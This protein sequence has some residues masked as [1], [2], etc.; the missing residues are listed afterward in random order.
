LIDPEDSSS[1]LTTDRTLLDIPSD[2]ELFSIAENLLKSNVSIEKVKEII[3]SV[4]P[5]F[6]FPDILTDVAMSANRR[7]KGFAQDVRDWI[8]LTKGYWHINDICKEMRVDGKVRLN[9]LYTVLN[10]LIKEGTIEHRGTRRGE[11][12][13]VEKKA[14]IMN[15]R[16]VDVQ[17]FKLWLPFDLMDEAIIYPKNIIVFAGEKSSGK[18][19]AMLNI[20]KHN[21]REHEIVYLCAEGGVVELRK[22]LDLFGDHI[23]SWDFTPIQRYSDWEDVIDSS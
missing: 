5:L 22:R 3:L 21:M 2:G 20:V 9:N 19:T 6:D 18:T 17:E 10:R 11:Y 4:N 7:E 1:Q 23:N 15:F 12:R 14:N 16:D 8:D 13:R